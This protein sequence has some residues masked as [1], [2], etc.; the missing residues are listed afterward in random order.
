MIKPNTAG[1]RQRF[2]YLVLGNGRSRTAPSQ[3]GSLC[4]ADFVGGKSVLETFC[5]TVMSG[6]M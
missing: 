4:G 3:A 2:L 6:E 5:P 1:F